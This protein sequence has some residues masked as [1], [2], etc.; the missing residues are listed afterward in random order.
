MTWQPPS[1]LDEGE[2]VLS[3]D[4][5]RPLLGDAT[6]TWRYTIDSTPP[7]LDVPAVADRTDRGEPVEISGSVEPDVTLVAAG[8]QVDVADDGSFTVRFARPP[9]G[10]VAFRATDEAGNTTTT[11]VVVPLTYPSMRAVHVT[12]PAWS[13]EQ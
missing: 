10:P 9:S 11:S 1:D 5:P 2:H 12:G 4:V 8:R 13:S 7:E 3:L 6:L